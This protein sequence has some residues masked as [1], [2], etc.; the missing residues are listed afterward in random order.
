M[1]FRQI[2]GH[3]IPIDILQRAVAGDRLPTGYLFAGPRNV[4]KTLT[5]LQLAKAIDCR[6]R[7]DAEDPNQVDCCDR[8]EVCRR[9]EDGSFAYF[10]LV[11]PTSKAL[12]EQL[13]KQRKRQQQGKPDQAENGEAGAGPRHLELIEIENAA[14][15]I[16]RVRDI[17]KS[18]NLKAP[19]GIWKIYLVQSAEKL[20]PEAGNLLLKTLE[21][22]PPRTTF[23]LTTSQPGDVLPTITSR[24]QVI[25]FG[26]VPSSQALPALR[27]EFPDSD[28]DAMAAVVAASAGRYGWAHR[29]LSHPAML[30]NRRALL[31]LLAGLP[32]QELFEGMRRAEELIALAEDW[33]VESYEADTAEAETAQA[34]LKSNR[35]AVLRTVMGQMLDTM[36][37]WWRDIALLVS[38][39]DSERVMNCDQLTELSRL[40]PIYDARDCRRALGWIEEAHA[41]FLGNANLR[42]TAELLMLKL[43]S[44]SPSR[45]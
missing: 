34:L 32:D 37:T 39:P 23:I 35:D 36:L 3:E 14:I 43:L 18:A 44:L 8:C 6:Q 4:G 26:P 9:I 24:C 22:P 11:F 28:P 12:Q 2:I 10:R 13:E 21:E 27:E 16:D 30:S 29:L 41:H 25:D 20:S 5:A 38:A 42:L 40:A 45:S 7:P 17:L 31:K 15:H 1:S 33:F 19:E